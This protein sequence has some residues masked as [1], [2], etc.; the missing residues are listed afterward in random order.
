MGVRG[1]AGQG[2]GMS[3][4]VHDYRKDGLRF[5]LYTDGNITVS[6]KDLP[7]RSLYQLDHGDFD[8]T[9]KA[10][11]SLCRDGIREGDVDDV[12]SAQALISK[13]RGMKRNAGVELY[14]ALEGLLG[15]IEESAGVDGYH[16]N[17][18]VAEW[19]EFEEVN[20][21]YEALAK[22]RGE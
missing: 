19:G 8:I 5:R 2:S 11:N 18:E 15:I 3:K 10:F 12:L 17:G 20:E 1:R 6:S 22:A 21:A 16:M 4:P 14:D 13:E 9:H 7:E